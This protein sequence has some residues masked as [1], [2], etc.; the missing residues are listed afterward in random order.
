M[1]VYNM[2]EYSTQM[3]QRH[4]VYN[5]KIYGKKIIGNHRYIFK[6]K[7]SSFFWGRQLRKK[8]GITYYVMTKE[9][10]L[11]EMVLENKGI[12]EF[13]QDIRKQLTSGKIDTTLLKNL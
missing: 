8:Q 7:R 3:A 12:L 11:I 2:Y 6:K 5:T 4:T 13:E 10:A 1:S 9:R